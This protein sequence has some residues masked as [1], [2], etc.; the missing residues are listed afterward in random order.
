MKRYALVIVICFVLIGFVILLPLVG[1]YLPLPKNPFIYYRIPDTTRPSTW[2][3][4][5]G[6]IKFTAA[7]TKYETFE[8]GSGENKRLEEEEVTMY[9][10]IVLDDGTSYDFFILYS[11]GEW[12]LYLFEDGK[13]ANNW[14]D[15]LVHFDVDYKSK[16][17][18]IAEVDG[19][20]LFEKGTRFEF[21]RTEP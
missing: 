5:D 19:G 3:S 18:F 21:R 13:E 12:N 16:K 6:R 20:S 7:D 14:D 2:E 1:A 10:E 8:F 4:T 11:I 15:Y 17:R 9:G